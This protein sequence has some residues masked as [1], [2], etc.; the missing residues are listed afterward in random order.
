MY[1]PRRGYVRNTFFQRKGNSYNRQR[2]LSK[3]L[4]LNRAPCPVISR[5]FFAS[6]G[7]RGPPFA[8]TGKHFVILRPRCLTTTMAHAQRSPPV[9]PLST[10]HA[11][12]NQDLF[13]AIGTKVAQSR[14]PA[15]TLNSGRR[16]FGG[17]WGAGSACHSWWVRSGVVVSLLEAVSGAGEHR[18][19][20]L[21]LR[22]ASDRAA[23]PADK[24]RGP[25]A[26]EALRA[27]VQGRQRPGGAVP[28]LSYS[29]ALQTAA[30]APGAQGLREP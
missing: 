23:E 17:P 26:I 25:P 5:Q 24:G 4:C 15:K 27:S 12:P 1:V 6:R 21:R 7:Y 29:R 19:P 13:R 9:T 30:E 22:A 11:P 28:G 16:W 20:A 18:K 14:A 3:L 8:A 2:K 10:S